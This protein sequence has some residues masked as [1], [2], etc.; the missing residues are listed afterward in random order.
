MYALEVATMKAR[1]DQPEVQAG[2]RTAIGETVRGVRIGMK[3]AVSA[4]Y[5]ARADKIFERRANQFLPDWYQEV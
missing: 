5:G 3:W 4:L 2:T 1:E